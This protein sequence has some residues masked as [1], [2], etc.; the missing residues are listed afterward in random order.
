MEYTIIHVL[1]GLLVFL[2]IVVVDGK[3]QTKKTFR[4]K[5]NY[6]TIIILSSITTT[7]FF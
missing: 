2:G 4:I 3:N 1:L 7:T 5:L 6:G